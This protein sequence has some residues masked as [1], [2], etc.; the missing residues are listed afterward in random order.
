MSIKQGE[1]TKFMLTDG[2]MLL[3][4]TAN[5]DCIEIFKEQNNDLTYMKAFK[6]YITFE[7]NKVFINDKY[8]KIDATMAF[9]IGLAVGEKDYESVEYLKVNK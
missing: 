6:Q 7:E 3:I 2:R 4:N 5:V 9:K 8:N 1:F